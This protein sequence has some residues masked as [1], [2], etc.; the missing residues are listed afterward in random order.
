MA[1][2]ARAIVM[3]V[4]LYLELRRDACG[5]ENFSAIAVEP[6]LGSNGRA[7]R[8]IGHSEGYTSVVPHTKG[9]R[10]SLFL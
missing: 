2:L 6:G 7:D 4:P 5:I 10:D 3:E 9:A 8:H 1:V